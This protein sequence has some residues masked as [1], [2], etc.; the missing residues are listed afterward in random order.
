MMGLSGFFFLGCLICLAGA[1]FSG[2]LIPRTLNKPIT[3]LE[4]LFSKKS[5][6]EKIDGRTIPTE[7]EILH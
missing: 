2:L 6:Y 7:K 1:L 4:H 3:E 5:K